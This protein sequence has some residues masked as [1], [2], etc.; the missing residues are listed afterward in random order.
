MKKELCI[1]ALVYN[2]VRVVMLEAARR[3][4][5]APNRISF[6][7]ALHWLKHVRPGDQMPL[8]VVNPLRPGR[9]E[10]RVRKRRPKPYSSMTKPRAEL[11]K[12]GENRKRR[13]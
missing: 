10:P 2:M 1:F 9:H 11:R 8:F 6:A 4:K 7:D 3:Q 5:V 12:T 13:A